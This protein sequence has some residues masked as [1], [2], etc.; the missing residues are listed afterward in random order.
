MLEVP[1]SQDDLE[2]L[3]AVSRIEFGFPHDFAGAALAYGN[4]FDLIDA[5]RR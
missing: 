4:T 5:H 2:R 1:L 3:D